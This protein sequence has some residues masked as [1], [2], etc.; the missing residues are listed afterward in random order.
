MVCHLETGEGRRAGEP[1]LANP[2]AEGAK[3]RIGGV[4][5]GEG[6]LLGI[7]ASAVVPDAFPDLRPLVEKQVPT[8]VA[9]FAPDLD[10]EEGGVVLRVEADLDLEGVASLK[11]VNDLR[12]GEDRAAV[13]EATGPGLH[14]EVAA[15]ERAPAEPCAVGEPHC[16]HGAGDR[17]DRGRLVESLFSEGNADPETRRCELNLARRGGNDEVG[18][19]SLVRP[20]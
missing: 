18:L 20:G 1:P 13:H 9:M 16:G 14:G 4:R 2:R 7:L 17:G 8:R 3:D 12:A 15:P 11:V 19:C 10:V 6:H 5:D